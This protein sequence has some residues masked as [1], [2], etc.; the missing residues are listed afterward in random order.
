MV[1]NFP[2]I[3]IAGLG[4]FMVVFGL[5]AFIAPQSFYDAVAGFGTY[6]VHLLHDVGA[7]QTGFG[8]ALLT[9]L[10]WSE[11]TKVVLAG[12][13]VGTVLHAIAHIVDRDLGKANTKLEPVELSVLAVV[14]V[15]AAMVALR[16]R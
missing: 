5:W 13:A 7:F 16:K 3:V 4:V 12:G 14:V 11:A 1:R 15:A 9:A 10:I 8:V 6:N 2:R